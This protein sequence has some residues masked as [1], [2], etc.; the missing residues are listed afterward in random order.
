VDQASAVSQIIPVYHEMQ[1]LDALVGTQSK[2]L[3]TTTTQVAC[4]Q[5]NQ[6]GPYF[7]SNTQML[8]NAGLDAKNAPTATFNTAFNFS[9]WPSQNQR[10]FQSAKTG[11]DFAELSATVLAEISQLTADSSALLPQLT[12]A[13]AVAAF[14][15]DVQTYTADGGK[16]A[17]YQ[18][19]ATADQQALDAAKSLADVSAVAKAVAKHRQDFA[20]PFLQVKAPHDMH[21]LTDLVSKANAITIYDPSDG[22]RYPLAYEYTSVYHGIGDASARLAN[23]QTLQ[24]Y[25]AVESEIQ[26]FTQNVTAMMNDY[27][28]M[29]K[30]LTK[31]ATWE[32]TPHQADLDLIK[33]YG[34]Q[35]TRVIV[36][37]F[38]EQ[39][40]RLY[41]NG[42]LT[43]YS[44]AGDAAH[45]SPNLTLIPD[46]QGRPDAFDVTTG[47]PDL[48]SV[49]G[50]HC[51]MPSKVSN[52]EDTAPASLVGTGYWYAPTHIDY[53]FGYADPG[54]A[55]HD[56]W[57]RDPPDG[58]G[59]GYLSNLPHP[60][61]LAFNNGSHGCINLHY[62]N[63]ATGRYDM[64]IVWAF[65]REGTPIIVY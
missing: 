24:D 57:W 56:A 10:A 8:A 27:A 53:S 59:M 25:Q 3:G 62:H 42:Q 51:V 63:E 34:V 20:L 64:A 65:A 14:Q 16:N 43:K 54:Y 1:A 22:G 7:V 15:A 21:A 58:G 12:A 32:A 28:Q 2:A 17:T 48:P 19:Q 18:Q 41:E 52:V 49:P 37:S 55:M 36:V 29:P 45:D 5:T 31:L 33:Y 4:A 44:I 47:N 46:P 9:S 40:A 50:I 11:A 38:A 26:M 30:D 60:A 35:N 13:A 23:A 6:Y 39:E 61:P